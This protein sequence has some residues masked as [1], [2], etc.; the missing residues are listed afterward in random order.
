[1]AERRSRI[2]PQSI[3]WSMTARG[4][5]ISLVSI[6]LLA[7]AVRP[8]LDRAN[9]SSE[10]RA[11]LDR[12]RLGAGGDGVLDTTVLGLERTGALLASWQAVGG[13]G[14]GSATGIGGIK[15]IGRNVSGGLVHVQ[16]QGNYTRLNKGFSFALQNQ[17]TGDLGAKW[18][19]GV[20]V[21]YL[22]KYVS[23]FAN[24]GYDLS[25][26]GLGDVNLLITRRLG[27]I[28]DTALTLSLGAP[29]GT[30]DANCM[31]L[32]K[33]LINCLPQ[34]RQLGSGS[35][36]GAL[37]LEHT[38]DNLWG[39]LVYG[40]TVA[41]PGRE[42]SLH[43]YRAPSATLYG[44]GG[45]LVGPLVP[46]FGLSV[47]AFTGHDRDFGNATERK[48]VM[49]AASTSLEWSNA[50]VALLAGVSVPFSTKGLEPW[51]AG[52]GVAFAPF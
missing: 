2:T 25:N 32:N 26:Q 3:F 1:M 40:G 39:P 51:T 48:A 15:W 47:T 16:S 11:H 6:A 9:A 46:A 13:C 21:P 34:D 50:W 24:Q 27:A 38:V 12:A 18:N 37:L 42:N 22:Y 43:D 29:T 49:A 52:L 44:Y 4:L 35:I 20:V 8:M 10:A 33:L 7:A 41:Y 14:A 23:N 28:N 30:H 19:V 36:S 17:I 5:A 31:E 45:Y